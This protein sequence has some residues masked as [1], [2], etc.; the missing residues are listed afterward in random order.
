MAEG[1]NKMKIWQIGYDLVMEIYEVTSK[2]PDIEKYALVQQMIKAANSVIA[3]IAESHGRY[4][5]LDKIRVMYISRGE[6]EEVQ[7]HLSVASGR[8]YLSK[9]KFNDLINRY[10]N[11]I[12]KI[13]EQIKYLRSKAD[14]K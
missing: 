1:F 14:S 3:N 6:A 7:S 12:I 8:D 4:Y 11:L 10:E 9:D 2:F 5:Y 13:N